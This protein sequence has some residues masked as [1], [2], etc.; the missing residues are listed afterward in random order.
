MAVQQVAPGLS[1]LNI[2][3]YFTV[4]LGQELRGSL[5]GYLRLKVSQEIVVKL[6]RRVNGKDN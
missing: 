1:S 3:C 6:R 5:H 2:I 4:A